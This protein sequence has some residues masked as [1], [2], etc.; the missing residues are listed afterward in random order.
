M[1]IIK[2]NKKKFNIWNLSFKWRYIKRFINTS[3][4]YIL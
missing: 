1:N 4:E 2:Y 3:N